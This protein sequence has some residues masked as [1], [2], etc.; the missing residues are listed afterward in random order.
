MLG[1]G[2][3][4]RLILV[5]LRAQA[6]AASDKAMGHLAGSDRWGTRARRVWGGVSGLWS[7]VSSSPDSDT[8]GCL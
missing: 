5:Q 1:P 3:R 2:W 7:D 4:G 8:G 6:L